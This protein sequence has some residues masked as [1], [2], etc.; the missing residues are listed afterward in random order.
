[1][2][3]YTQPGCAAAAPAADLPFPAVRRPLYQNTSVEGHRGFSCY[4]ICQAL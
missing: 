4:L 2:S 1:M 3:L